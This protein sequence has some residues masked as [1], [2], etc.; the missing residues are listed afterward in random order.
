MLE[1]Y[2]YVNYMYF[3]LTCWTASALET[4][5]WGDVLPLL[6]KKGGDFQK[7]GGPVYS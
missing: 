6:M 1:I 4:E 5:K 2:F 3:A 7:E